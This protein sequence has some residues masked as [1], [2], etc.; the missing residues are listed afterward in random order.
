MAAEDEI[1]QR[2]DR[3][4][5]MGLERETAIFLTLLSESGMDASQIALT[6]MMAEHAGREML[7]MMLMRGRHSSAPPAVI[8]RGEEVLIVDEGTLYVIDMQSMEVTSRLQ[9][10]TPERLE[11]A[12]IFSLLAPLMAG[13]HHGAEQRACA[14]NLTQIGLA[15]MMYVQD[16]GGVLPAEAWA[17]TLLEYTDNEEVFVCP[18]RPDLPVGYAFNEKLLGVSLHQLEEPGETVVA[19]GS[20]IGGEAPVGG[21]DDVPLEGVHEDGVNCLYAD[22]RVEWVFVEEA[23]E[24]LAMP[25]Q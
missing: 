16:K 1:Q 23:R 12:P 18:A 6:M 17:Q 20:N 13:A 24:L 8:D 22:G 3:F 7:P 2:V 5:E 10:D 21:P 4:V 11:D 19:F 9:Y 25:V 14:A 15:L